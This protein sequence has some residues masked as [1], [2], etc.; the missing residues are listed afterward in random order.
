MLQYAWGRGRMSFVVSLVTLFY[1]LN[2][3]MWQYFLDS[4]NM[5]EPCQMV[6]GWCDWHFVLVVVLRDWV[7]MW[8]F[9][10]F[11]NMCVLCGVF[12]YVSEGDENGMWFCPH[13]IWEFKETLWNL[14]V[15]YETLKYELP[16]PFYLVAYSPPSLRACKCI[17]MGCLLGAFVMLFM[18]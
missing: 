15:V 4:D 10:M 16:L 14:Y 2:S 12:L 1:Y 9:R 17:W 7:L 11:V 5:L 8:L 3:W 18:W 13:D 6:Y